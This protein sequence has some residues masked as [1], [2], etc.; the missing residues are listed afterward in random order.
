MSHRSLPRWASA[1]PLAATLLLAGAAVPAAATGAENH[2]EQIRQDL[3]VTAKG[4]EN[5]ECR[6]VPADK[7]GWHFVLPGNDTVF[8]KLTVTFERGGEQVITDF[9]PPSDKHAYAASEPGAK[10]VAAVAETEGAD[11]KYFNLS[12]TCPAS[13]APEQPGEENPGEENPGE[14]NPG[15]E[16]PGQEN[17]GEEQPCEEQ[18]GGSG[19]GQDCQTPP[20]TGTGTDGDEDAGCDEQPG[21]GTEGGATGQP[22]EAPTGQPT[23]QATASPAP[24]EGDLAETGAGSTVGL[25]FAAALLLAAGGAIVIRN[26]RAGSGS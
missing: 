4:F 16:N 22:T 26:R 1:L 21:G 20:C 24:V 9:G 8:T 14:E 17:P 10:L 11:V 18:Q 12:H 7:D 2:T 13:S 5:G 15:E 6:T 23:E 3:P 19:D 25:A